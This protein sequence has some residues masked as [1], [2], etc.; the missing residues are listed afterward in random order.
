MNETFFIWLNV[1]D[2]FFMI[3]ISHLG[4]LSL[5]DI[6]I[7]LFFYINDNI[8]SYPYKNYV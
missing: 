8:I 7:F 1:N 5:F 3:I 2:D 6:I 4:L